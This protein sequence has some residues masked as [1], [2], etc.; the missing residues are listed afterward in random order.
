ML[1]VMM[2]FPCFFP[3]HKKSAQSADPCR[4]IALLPQ[5]DKA[6]KICF[7]HLELESLQVTL[8]YMELESLQVTST[9]SKM[10]PNN[11]NPELINPCAV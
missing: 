9:Y 8:T 2:A 6:F 3:I 4:T 5:G 10:S 7:Q 1:K 11:V